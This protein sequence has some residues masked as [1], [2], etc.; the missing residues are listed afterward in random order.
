MGSRSNA[1]EVTVRMVVGAGLAAGAGTVL[2]SPDVGA[3]ADFLA[4]PLPNYA[5]VIAALEV[6]IWALVALVVLWSAAGVAAAAQSRLPAHRHQRLWGAGVLVLG[7]AILLA[8]LN[9]HLSAEAVS[10]GG[11]SAEEASRLLER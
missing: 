9:H 6:M 10:L 11:G 3:A 4:G 1:W 8:G 7:L 5:G 2:G